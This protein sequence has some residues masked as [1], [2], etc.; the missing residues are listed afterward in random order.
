MNSRSLV[1]RAQ[2]AVFCVFAASV[3]C[4]AGLQSGLADTDSAL[5]DELSAA[6]AS[7]GFTGTIEAKFAEKLGRPIKS[8]RADLGRLLWFDVIGGLNGDNTCGGCHSPTNGFGDT[9][10][11]AIGVGNNNIVGPGRVDRQRVIHDRGQSTAIERG[12]QL[13][14]EEL[15]LD[16]C[17]DD[18]QR[19]SRAVLRTDV[20]DHRHERQ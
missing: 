14:G 15:V 6:L 8:K 1:T 19:V 5:D 20:H 18:G 9:Q 13:R 7:H 4:L 16:P 2:R 12:V 17:A 10:P 11:I 3:L